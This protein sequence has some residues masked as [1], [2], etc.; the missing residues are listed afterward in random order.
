MEKETI[1]LIEVNTIEKNWNEKK[2]SGND[3]KTLAGVSIVD[4]QAYK[5][6]KN[7]KPKEMDDIEK[8]PVQDGDIFITE[9]RSGGVKQGNF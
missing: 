1:I 6:K 9:S 3:V 2:I 4:N 8:I 5:I 7:D